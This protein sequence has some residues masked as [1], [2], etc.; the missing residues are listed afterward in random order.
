MK[1]YVMLGLLV[2]AGVALVACETA[3]IQETPEVVAYET[4][5]AELQPLRL[6]DEPLLLLDDEPAVDLGEGAA[7]NSRCHVCHMNYMSDSL[8]LTHAAAG[9]GCNKCHGESDEH[10]ADESW[11]WGGKGTA[12]DDMYTLEQINPFCT[13]C[14]NKDT[15][16]MH[17]A[18]L[19]G[20]SEAKY[21]TDC[22]G[23]HRMAVRKMKWK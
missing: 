19:A 16:Q 18:V 9:M 6:D 1:Y 7:D 11:A 20:T 8:A 15:L 4:P 17:E 3:R 23:E 21:C 2:A 5:S 22:H 10:I 14:H 12:P 13:G